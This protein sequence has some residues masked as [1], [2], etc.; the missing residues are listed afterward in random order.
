MF[1]E[2][3]FVRVDRIVGWLSV[4]RVSCLRNLRGMFAGENGRG[5]RSCGCRLRAARRKSVVS[6]TKRRPVV[7]MRRFGIQRDPAGH[8]F[9]DDHVQVWWVGR[10]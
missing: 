2:R 10:M 8:G 1:L 4:G 6:L 5:M 7:R 3:V 9:G